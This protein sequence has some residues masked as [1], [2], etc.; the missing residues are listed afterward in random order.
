MTT[1]SAET[2]SREWEIARL[3]LDAYL[4]RIA[5]GVPLA[6]DATTLRRLH[7]A[8]AATI[9]FENL[10]IVL[11]RGIELDLDRI[12]AKLV[13]RAR[14]GYCYEHNLLF[15]AA[16]EQ[17]GFEVTRL[18]ARVQPKRGGLRTHMT[19][20]VV[21]D[22]RSWLADV[23]FGASLLE[24]LLLEPGVSR[25]GAWSY[26]LD[27]LGDAGWLLSRGETGDWTDMY[28]FT[29]EPQRR[30]DYEVF[31]HFT[32]T[33]PRSPFV[34]RVVALRTEDDVRYDLRGHELT[35]TRPDEDAASRQL[36]TA[37]LLDVLAATFGIGLD[38][39]ETEAL[40][41]AVGGSARGA[42]RTGTRSLAP[43][44]IAGVDSR[45]LARAGDARAGTPIERSSTMA[46]A[47]SELSSAGDPPRCSAVSRPSRR[48]SSA[49]GFAGAL[50]AGAHA[51]SS[52]S[53]R[54]RDR[55]R[56]TADEATLHGDR[57]AARPPP[58]GRSSSVAGATTATLCAVGTY[59]PEAGQ[60]ACLNAPAGRFV[61]STGAIS[62]TPCVAGTYQPSEGQTSCLNAPA[63]SF[64][65]DAS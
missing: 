11:G 30:S 49:R 39:G 47:T 31:N 65:G 7:R 12:Q 4:A 37:E 9:P 8:H 55:L 23:G 26:R 1:V 5:V 44:R 27:A 52:P 33:H 29:L 45:E 43:T 40:R 16:L 17:I 32:A 18:A 59:E 41:R 25:Q 34:G 21:A 24:P 28:A 2:E 42:D 56:S 53:R 19:L 36:S 22:G 58:R 14:G 62:A 6:P 20:R 50:M 54:A 15:A 64:V 35:T 38:A 10:D 60:A 3:D 51:R 48:S 61:D 57:P 46:P 13:G 63:G